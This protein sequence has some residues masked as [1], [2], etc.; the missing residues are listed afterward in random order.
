[1]KMTEDVAAYHIC[2]MFAD[3]CSQ[4]ESHPFDVDSMLFM[5]WR[6]DHTTADPAMHDSNLKY[7]A[8]PCNQPICV[9]WAMHLPLSGIRQW[10][11]HIGSI[12]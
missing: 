6:D 3:V 9:S 11:L 7:A 8:L 5:D 1:M 4:V 12:S 10:H 2:L